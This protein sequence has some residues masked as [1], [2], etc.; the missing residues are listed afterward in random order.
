MY[1]IKEISQMT[2][3]TSY[4]LRYY[5]KEGILPPIERDAGGRRVYSEENLAWVELV[6]CLKKTQMPVNDIKEIV[7]LSVIGDETIDERKEILENH[8]LVMQAQM[9][10]L[11]NSIKKID[12]KIA[13]YNGSGSC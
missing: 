12:K 3:V 7:R 10:D 13:F 11:K 2:G 1:T 8:R 4:T 6:T 5:E 9:K